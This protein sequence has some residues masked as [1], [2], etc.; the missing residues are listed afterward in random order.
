MVGLSLL[1]CEAVFA[2]P[3]LKAKNADG[4]RQQ[5]NTARVLGSRDLGTDLLFFSRKKKHF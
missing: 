3:M 4:P 5:G 1:D 2:F